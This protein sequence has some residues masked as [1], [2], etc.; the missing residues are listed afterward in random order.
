MLWAFDD[1][2]GNKTWKVEK[3]TNNYGI[4]VKD[5][6][7]QKMIAPGDCNARV[8][9]GKLI[10][11]FKKLK[12]NKSKSNPG[13]VQILKK[14]FQAKDFYKVK[15]NEVYEMEMIIE[16]ISSPKTGYIARG[17][18]IGTANTQVKIT[19]RHEDKSLVGNDNDTIDDDV[20]DYMNQDYTNYAD[21][22]DNTG[23]DDDDDNGGGE[24]PG[25]GNHESPI[26]DSDKLRLIG[27][28]ADGTF[29]YHGKKYDTLQ[30]IYAIVAAEDSGS[31]DGAWGVITS[32][33][34]RMGKAKWAGNGSNLIEQ[35]TA[36]NQYAV[37]AAIDKYFTKGNPIPQNA[38]NGA[39]KLIDD[40]KK[41]HGFD[42]FKTY[43]TVKGTNWIEW[44]EKKVM[45]A[46][47]CTRSQLYRYCR[48]IGGNYYHNGDFSAEE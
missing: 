37:S 46:N 24:N 3:D 26:P 9:D 1:T 11:T 48:K 34:N 30:L 4:V 18:E 28:N 38:I 36:P 35:L 7:G 41:N 31:V 20:E 21:G 32:A 44:V 29:E 5:A 22:G 17:K 6:T 23:G 15:A 33:Y 27:G 19:M 39:N 43:G 14:H 42:S 12:S 25:G 10:L 40:R 2:D 13:T 47:N 8:E 16:G 45:E